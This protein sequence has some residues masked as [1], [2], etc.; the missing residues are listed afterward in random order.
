[1]SEESTTPD[2]VEL[3]RRQFE[4]VNRG[5]L[6]ALLSFFAPDVVVDLSQRDLPS[7]EGVPAIRGFL[8]D[9]IGSYEE[10]R[11]EPEEVLDLGNGVVFAVVYQNA[12]PA[13]STGQVWQREG[14]VWVWVGDLTA[15][16]TTYGD[17]DEARA[18]AERFAEE[19]G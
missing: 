14:W 5:D 17:I 19:R 2:L 16:M 18:A 6:D 13:G 1:M 10:L 7:F 8:E 3:T 4:A 9:W 15:R 11:W 12:R